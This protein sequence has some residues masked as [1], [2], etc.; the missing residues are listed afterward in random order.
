M[1]HVVR[2]DARVLQTGVTIV[3]TNGGIVAGIVRK[4]IVPN[5]TFLERLQNGRS[6]FQRGMVVSEFFDIRHAVAIISV[7]FYRIG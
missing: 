1:K 2:F 5:I 6:V 4:T 3:R 7:S